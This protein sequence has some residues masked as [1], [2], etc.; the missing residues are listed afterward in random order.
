MTPP[1]S[2][3]AAIRYGFGLSPNVA[4][5]TDLGE[6]LGWLR[7]PDVIVAQ[8]PIAGFEP[9]RRET[10]AWGNCAKR[11]VRKLTAPRRLSRRPT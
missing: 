3:F 6:M 5:P 9:R 8:F 10:A 2:T 11:C 1:F 4:A 7:E